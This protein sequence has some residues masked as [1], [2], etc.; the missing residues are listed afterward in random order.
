MHPDV[1]KPSILYIYAA[2]ASIC[3]LFI[4]GVLGVFWNKR[5]SGLL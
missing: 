1:F 2:S 4:E 5:V 3:L